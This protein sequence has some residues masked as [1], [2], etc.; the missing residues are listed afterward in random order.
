MVE[1]APEYLKPHNMPRERHPM[2][3]DFY[4]AGHRNY[5]NVI[6]HPGVGFYLVMA[7]TRTNGKTFYRGNE[8]IK[9]GFDV[10]FMDEQGASRLFIKGLDSA[11]DA[12]QSIWGYLDAIQ[13]DLDE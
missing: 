1:E 4:I 8:E 12:F 5:S 13:A 6:R 10:Y 3:R 11:H 7:N 2:T 9:K